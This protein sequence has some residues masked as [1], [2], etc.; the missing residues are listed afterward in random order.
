M[1]FSCAHGRCGSFSSVRLD[2]LL[3]SAFMGQTS[4]CCGSQRSRA[5]HPCFRALTE[6]FPRISRPPAKKPADDD[7][8]GE[9]TTPPPRYQTYTR[10][11]LVQAPTAVKGF[12]P[13][14]A[15]N[16]FETFVAELMF[17]LCEVDFILE[18]APTHATRFKSKE[19][20]ALQ[21]QKDFSA[22]F[23]PIGLRHAHH[24]VITILR[25][26]FADYERT[27]ELCMPTNIG[28]FEGTRLWNDI[29]LALAPTSSM[30]C[31]DALQ[32]LD[33][34]LHFR[35][36]DWGATK[37]ELLRLLAKVTDQK[38]SVRD[39]LGMCLMQGL[40]QAALEDA[41]WRDTHRALLKKAE[42]SWLKHMGHPDRLATIIEECNQTQALILQLGDDR[43]G[44][45]STKS[46]GDHSNK[47]MAARLPGPRGGPQ[48]AKAP[49]VGCG[50]CP[51]H[52][53]VNGQWRLKPGS[54][55][56][57]RRPTKAFPALTNGGPDIAEIWPGPDGIP[58]S[59]TQLDA[60]RLEL[61][62]DIGHASD[63]E[64]AQR[65]A[66]VLAADPD[67][68]A[69]LAAHRINAVED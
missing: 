67:Y 4:R 23:G 20:D 19:D 28:T 35:G 6:F 63:Q 27:Q 59:Q 22:T 36:Q 64:A 46:L 7:A 42:K 18:L 32:M 45:Q 13:S 60:L 8:D 39:L 38:L 50:K 69:Y 29:L 68:Q 2:K 54:T 62:Y 57:S 14:T 26:V 53:Q 52:C 66:Q 51:L 49:C 5:K 30:Q 33:C 48:T 24:D 17:Y 44:R 31:D 37:T 58:L 47:A 16:D 40:E 56:V 9:T 11:L 25:A 3:A 34:G 21:A 12:D 61:G 43:P 15:M 55:A 65:R 10:K 41:D 1:L